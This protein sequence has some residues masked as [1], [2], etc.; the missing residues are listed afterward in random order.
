MNYHNITNVDMVNGEGLRVV[1]WLSGCSHAC[2][3]CHNQ[4]T[5]DPASGILFD[6]EAKQ[7]LFNYLQAEYISGVTLS[8]GDPFYIDHREEVKELLKEIKRSFPQKSIWVYTGYIME[9]ISDPHLLESIDVL[10]DGMFIEALS[11]VEYP[12]AGSENQR[13]IDVAKSLK[14]G[15]VVLY[16]NH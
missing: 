16:E 14:E 11:S 15:E 2:P 10:V 9:E 8:G 7:E 3:S 4:K 6:G 13:I 5:W 12:W 1:L